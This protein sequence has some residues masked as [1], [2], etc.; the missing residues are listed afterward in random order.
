MVDQLESRIVVE[1]DRVVTTS[2][3]RLHAPSQWDDPDYWAFVEDGRTVCGYSGA[4]RIPGLF[5]RMGAERCK[6]CCRMTGMPH[7]RG[8]PKND[9]ACRLLVRQHIAAL[10]RE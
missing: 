8:S 9:D 10:I 6:R 4:L 5:T 3:A 7:G 2:Y 1:W